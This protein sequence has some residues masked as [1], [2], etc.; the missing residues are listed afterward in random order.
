[1]PDLIAWA[2][3]EKTLED[4]TLFQ[5]RFVGLAVVAMTYLPI[6]ANLNRG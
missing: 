3:A 1:M 4:R 2:G 5:A 6:S